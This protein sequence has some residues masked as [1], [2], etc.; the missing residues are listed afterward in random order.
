MS[1]ENVLLLTHNDLN[2][3]FVI[4][5]GLEPVTVLILLSCN[6]QYPSKLVMLV[7]DIGGVIQQY[8]ENNLLLFMNIYL[9]GYKSLKLYA[10]Y[11][12]IVV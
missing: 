6:Y 8:L 2:L 3:R 10:F 12:W 4:A 1:Y 9:P 11:D 7:W 5:K